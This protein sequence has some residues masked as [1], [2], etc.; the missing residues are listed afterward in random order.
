M[1]EIFYTE[2]RFLIYNAASR[3]TQ[4]HFKI[5][6]RS[7][8]FENNE[9]MFYEYQ[10]HEMHRELFTPK[11]KSYIISIEFTKLHSQGKPLY[12]PKENTK[13]LNYIYHGSKETKHLSRNKSNAND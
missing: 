5:L 2:L 13:Q 3:K 12:D 11:E 7:I 10:K 4:K 1:Y 9:V 8:L 6:K